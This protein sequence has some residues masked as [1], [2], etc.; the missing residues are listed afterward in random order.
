MHLHGNGLVHGDVRGSNILITKEGEIK[1]G[2]FGFSRLKEEAAKFFGSPAFLA[3]EIV[4]GHKNCDDR[5][6]VWSLGI[7]AIELGDGKASFQ[8]VHPTRALFQIVRNPPPTL[9]RPSNWTDV[10]NDFVEE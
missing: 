1:I 4:V 5:I 9:Y 3:P 10:Y 8:Q 2:D 7:T 6:D